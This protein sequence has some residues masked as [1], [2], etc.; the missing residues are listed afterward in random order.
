M[1]LTRQQSIE[2]TIEAYLLLMVNTVATMRYLL[3]GYLLSINALDVRKLFIN[4]CEIQVLAISFLLS[5]P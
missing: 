1:F 3:L 5:S 4:E 2:T